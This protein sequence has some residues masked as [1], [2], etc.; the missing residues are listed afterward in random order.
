MGT[1]GG[2]PFTILFQA[3]KWDIL[4]SSNEEFIVSMI[5][6]EMAVV[7]IMAPVYVRYA[8]TIS[9]KVPSRIGT[10]LLVVCAKEY[11]LSKAHQKPPRTRE[12]I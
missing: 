1:S 10:S 5:A 7:M 8:K 3:T 11:T 2:Q 4:S 12:S 6:V 9:E